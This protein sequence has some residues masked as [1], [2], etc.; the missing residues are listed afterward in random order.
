MADVDLA[1]EVL[2]DEGL[3]RQRDPEDP[4]LRIVEGEAVVVVRIDR[5]TGNW[6]FTVT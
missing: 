2:L 3:L 4:V 5:S 6:S 1:R